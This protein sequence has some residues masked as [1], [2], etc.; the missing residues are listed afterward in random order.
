[1]I[2]NKIIN[3]QRLK[4]EIAESDI[5]YESFSIVSSG[6]SF[7]ITFSNELSS[8]DIEAL[9]ILVIKHKPVPIP[10]GMPDTSVTARQV[11]TA[12]ILSGVTLDQISGILDSLPEP[13]KTVAKVAWE[14]SY[15]FHRDNE[16][17]ISLAPAVGLT[18]ED[19]DNLWVLAK[20]L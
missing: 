5:T 11:R 13:N 1:M 19:L 17:V 9:S 12:L 7:E 15:R 8:G 16:L 10:K 6:T 4:L 3:K 18:T 14:H 2:F 20:S